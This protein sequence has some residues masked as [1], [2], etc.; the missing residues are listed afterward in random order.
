MVTQRKPRPSKYLTVPMRS[1]QVD[2]DRSVAGLLEK[3]EGAGFGARQ[4]AESH[5]IWLDMLGDNTTIFVAASGALIPAGMRR[6]LAYVI[7]NRFVDVLVCSGSMLFHD[8]HETLGRQHFQSHPSMTDAEL[9]SAQIGAHVG[10]VSRARRSIARRT[11]GS[12]VSPINSTRRARIRRANFCTCWGVNWPKL[13]P[14]TASHFRLQVARAG[15][16]PDHLRQ[17]DHGRH[18]RLALRE[19]EHLLLRSRAGRARHDANRRARARHRRHQHRRR[20]VA[21]LYPADGSGDQHRQDARARPQVRDSDLDRHAAPRRTL[22]SPNVNDE[23]LIFGKLA[24]GA[25]TAYVNCDATIALPIFVTSLSQTAA[26]Y[27]KGRKR[28]SFTFTRT[29]VDDRSAVNAT[30]QKLGAGS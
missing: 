4:L 18:R 5:R 23:S 8:L 1:V 27:M 15:L 19:E 13:R 26:K 21:Q 16:L 20:N 6:L 9:E 30:S 24:R 7:K 3:M 22:T 29:R 11:N 25:A 2:R 28:P 10:R 17:R 12:A 14:K